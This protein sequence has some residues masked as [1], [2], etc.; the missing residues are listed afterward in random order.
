VEAATP[1]VYPT[2]PGDRLSW[3]LLNER[4]NVALNYSTDL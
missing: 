4:V 3:Y 2:C 1:W